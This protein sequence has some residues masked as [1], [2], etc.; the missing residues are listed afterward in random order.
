MAAEDDEELRLVRASGSLLSDLEINLPKLLWKS[1]AKTGGHR[2]SHQ[3]VKAG[4]L[5]FV[6]QLVF[7]RASSFLKYADCHRSSLSKVSLNCWMQS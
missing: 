6:I 5:E 3:Y 7:V 4:D 2:K 1:P